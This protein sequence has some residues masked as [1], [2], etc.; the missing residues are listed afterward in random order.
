MAFWKWH[1]PEEK[2]DPERDLKTEEIPKR[3]QDNSK[4][5]RNKNMNI[6]FSQDEIEMIN[7]L[8]KLS[9]RSKTDFILNSAQGVP[10]VNLEGANELLVE[11]KRQGNNLNQLARQA[12]T[13]NGLQVAG[14]QEHLE[15]N[16]QLRLA[17][18][19]LIKEWDIK[20]IKA[21]SEKGDEQNGDSE[22]SPQ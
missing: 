15:E 11:L 6:R 5:T 2:K 14:L 19:E 16:R 10:I 22:S 4:R 1:K 17:L 8:V 20:C 7:R 12:N 9:G 21:I 3:Q 18:M 13:E